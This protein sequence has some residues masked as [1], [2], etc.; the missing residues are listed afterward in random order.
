ML[1]SIAVGEV[2]ILVIGLV[3]S[4]YADETRFQ[5]MFKLGDMIEQ[6][7]QLSK[8]QTKKIIA[9]QQLNNKQMNEIEEQTNK[10][11]ALQGIGHRLEKEIEEQIDQ[12]ETLQQFSKDQTNKIETLQRISREGKNK[13]EKL[14]STEKSGIF[15]TFFFGILSVLNTCGFLGYIILKIYESITSN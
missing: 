4:V 1:I 15:W 3:L 8:D 9:L 11:V 13:I 12:I 2:A 6:I 5:V 14:I 10:I 7:L